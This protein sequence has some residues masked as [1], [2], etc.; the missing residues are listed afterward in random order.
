MDKELEGRRLDAM[1]ASTVMGWERTERTGLRWNDSNSIP[2][3]LPHYST[4]IAAAF[5]VIDKL[6]EQ[7]WVGI[8][9][10]G[11]KRSDGDEFEVSLYS[12]YWEQE[13]PR[14]V[15]VAETI[16]LAICRAALTA[17][18]INS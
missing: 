17:M 3:P 5:L 1:V 9:I 2:R 6:H 4:D 12:D 16:P 11:G 8:Q 15:A 7:Y 14:F 18:E 10:P 13:T